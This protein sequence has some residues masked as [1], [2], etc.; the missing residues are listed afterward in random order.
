MYTYAKDDGEESENKGQIDLRNDWLLG[1]ESPWRVYALGR[2]EYDNFQNWD[3]RV[4]AFAGIGYEFIKTEKTTLIGRFGAGASREF[5]G[6]DNRITPELNF[7]ADFEHK[8]TDT[9]K[10][11]ASLDYYPSLLNFS[12][13][14]LVGKAGY[15]ILLD[16]ES[17]LSLKLGV[18][19]RYD[20]SPDGAKRNDLDY[21]VLMV[22][23]F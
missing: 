17:G 23:K 6:D 15:E 14:R 10:I 19:D 22:F 7:G 12:D 18:E 20:S 13:F 4:S 5:G 8:F 2:V 16:P 9:Q 1:K 21:F 11:F 3:W